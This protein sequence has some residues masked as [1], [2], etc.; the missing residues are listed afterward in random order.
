M[1]LITD[2]HRPPLGLPLVGAMADRVGVLEQVHPDV[3]LRHVVPSGQAGLEQQRRLHALGDGDAVDLDADVARAG[4]HV[5]ARVR[6]ARVREHLLVLLEPGVHR[7]PVE[8]DRV[9][10]LG[11]RGVLEA[12]RRAPDALDAEGPAVTAARRVI[13]AAVGLEQ[14][15]A[16]VVNRDVVGRVVRL[17]PHVQRPGGVG[18]QLAAQIRPHPL[19]AGLGSYLSAHQLDYTV[20][21]NDPSGHYGAGP[22][23]A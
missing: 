7:A 11:N 8:P 20:Q 2:A 18:D 22:R 4:E 5:D 13:D 14:L 23:D 3:G 16:D 15:G 10:Q 17:L 21:V 12:D 19:G 1:D 6:I 9:A